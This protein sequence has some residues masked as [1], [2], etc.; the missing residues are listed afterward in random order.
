M[1]YGV[2]NIKVLGERL[3][4]VVMVSTVLFMFGYERECH[5]VT[6]KSNTSECITVHGVYSGN[7]GQ[8]ANWVK[9]KKLSFNV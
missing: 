5:K 4:L 1:A 9:I 8:G 7:L 6:R 2:L 3:D